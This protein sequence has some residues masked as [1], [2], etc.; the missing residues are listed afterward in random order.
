MKRNQDLSGGNWRTLC[1][2]PQTAEKI[3]TDLG[4]TIEIS[5][6]KCAVLETAKILSKTPKPP[7]V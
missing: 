3:S 7:G 6:Q 1:C 2:D 4:T 5:V